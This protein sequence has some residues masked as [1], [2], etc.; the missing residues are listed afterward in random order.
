VAATLADGIALLTIYS[1]G[2]GVPFLLAALFTDTLSAKLKSFGRLG[3]GLRALAG[4]VMIAMGVA[5]MTGYLS[6]FAFWLLETF[7]VLS[8]IG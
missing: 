8:S 4:V 2:L 3:R 1:L 6:S 5:M 7:P